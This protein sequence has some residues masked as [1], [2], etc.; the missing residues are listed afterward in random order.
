MRF[1]FALLWVLQISGL[2]SEV[3]GERGKIFNTFKLQHRAYRN[4]IPDSSGTSYIHTRLHIHTNLVPYIHT[5]SGTVL[6]PEVRL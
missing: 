4:K 5:M 1:C 6:L 3:L 2:A